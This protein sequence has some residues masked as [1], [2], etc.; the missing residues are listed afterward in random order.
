MLLQREVALIDHSYLSSNRDQLTLTVRSNFSEIHQNR[1][2]N[3]YRINTRLN[4]AVVN[5]A[6]TAPVTEDV[7]VGLV[8]DDAILSSFESRQ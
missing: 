4:R 2:L 3:G 7:F 1:Y 5:A 8:F 6:K